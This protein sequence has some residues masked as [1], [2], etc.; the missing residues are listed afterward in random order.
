MCFV[1]ADPRGSDNEG[2]EQRSRA[3]IL[4]CNVTVIEYRKP[5]FCAKADVARKDTHSANGN[6][7][8][9]FIEVLQTKFQTEQLS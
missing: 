2:V 7:F 6:H 9:L 5:P 1:V 3:M 8:K 4:Q